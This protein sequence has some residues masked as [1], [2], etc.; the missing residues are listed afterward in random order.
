MAKIPGHSRLQTNG[1][2]NVTTPYIRIPYKLLRCEDFLILSG[3]AIK[4]YCYLLSRW[5][6]HKPDDFIEVSYDVLCKKLKKGKTQISRASKELLVSGY[7]YKVTRYKQCNR[8]YIEQ[9]RF[10]G[11]Y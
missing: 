9:K 1:I 8:Y 11:E 2:L 4:L 5:S 6:T 10:T 3:N 7:V